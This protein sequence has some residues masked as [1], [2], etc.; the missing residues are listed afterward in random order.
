[1]TDVLLTFVCVAVVAWG[2]SIGGGAQ[3]PLC[4]SDHYAAQTRLFLIVLGANC[5]VQGDLMIVI[6]GFDLNGALQSFHGVVVVHGIAHFGKA[7]CHSD[8]FPTV[9]EAIFGFDK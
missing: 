5:S 4:H 9:L 2:V 1:M 7:H 3:G 8:Y 6:Q